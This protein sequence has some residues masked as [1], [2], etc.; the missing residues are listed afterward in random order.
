MERNPNSLNFQVFTTKDGTNNDGNGRGD[1][2]G[3]SDIRDSIYDDFIASSY[4]RDQS[5]IYG[6]KSILTSWFGRSSS[7]DRGK[8][9]KSRC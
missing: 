8:R 5:R 7:N 2:G 1:I 9:P 3:R 6:D 4:F